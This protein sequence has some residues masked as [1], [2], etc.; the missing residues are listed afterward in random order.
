VKWIKYGLSAKIV[1]AE[2]VPRIEC[3]HNV[4]MLLAAGFPCVL[5]HVEDADVF[6]QQ[7]VCFD[8]QTAEVIRVDCVARKKLLPP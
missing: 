1:A 4:R 8:A 3:I 6:I 7:H 5:R 2:A